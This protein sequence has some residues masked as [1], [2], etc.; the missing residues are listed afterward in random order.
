MSYQWY[1]LIGNVGVFLILTSYLLLQLEKIDPR[2][3]KYSLLNTVGAVAVLISLYFE[4]NLSAFIIE[5][6]WLI[7]SLIG[8]FK[9]F[10]LKPT[11]EQ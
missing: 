6:F 11:Q 8:V 1:D 9:F 2:S 3:I 10:Y 7:I 5:I 4:F